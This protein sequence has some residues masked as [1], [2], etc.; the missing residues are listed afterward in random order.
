MFV[1]HTGSP[2]PSWL[3]LDGIV[4]GVKLLFEVLGNGTSVGNELG[5]SAPS[6][7]SDSSRTGLLFTT[8]LCQEPFARQ[9]LIPSGAL[10]VLDQEVFTAIGPHHLLEAL[11][12]V[13]L[14]RRD[15]ELLLHARVDDRGYQP[16]QLLT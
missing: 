6:I 7:P 3:L 10:P 9:L 16:L 1:I 5:P 14:D 4:Y 12:V 13:V 11:R 8:C 2:P 15:D